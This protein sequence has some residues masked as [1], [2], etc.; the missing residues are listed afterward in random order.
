[1]GRTTAKRGSRAAVVGPTPSSANEPFGAVHKHQRRQAMEDDVAMHKSSDKGG[2]AQP[3]KITV[4]KF[5]TAVPRTAILEDE[6]PDAGPAIKKDTAAPPVGLG[7]ISAG[8]AASSATT[9]S[10]L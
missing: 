4:N 10:D 7:E 1:M 5:F 6:G 3:A 8:A 9:D 2:P